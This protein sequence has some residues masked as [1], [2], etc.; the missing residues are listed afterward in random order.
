MYKS[1]RLMRVR[2]VLENK[3]KIRNQN[4]AEREENVEFVPDRTNLMVQVNI[5]ATVPIPYSTSSAATVFSP[6]R[7]L[8]CIL[9]SYLLFISV[10]FI[11]LIPAT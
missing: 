1:V 2:T 6:C 9:L 5:K 4:Y 7:V 11:V 10:S 8:A 3:M